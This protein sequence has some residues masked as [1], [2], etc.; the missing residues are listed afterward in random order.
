MMR[1]CICFLLPLIV[2][3]G[4]AQQPVGSLLYEVRI[5]GQR[6]PGY[7]FGTVHLADSSLVSWSRP[8]HRALRRCRIVAGE[9]NLLNPAEQLQS[10][11][12][13]LMKDTL[14]SDL[15]S[16]ADSAVVWGAIRRSADP[17]LAVLAN[18]MKPMVLAVALLEQVKPSEIHLIPDVRIQQVGAEK[19]KRIVAL[20]TAEEHYGAMDFLSYRE[21]TRLLVD[22]AGSADSLRAAFEPMRK[23]YLRGDVELLAELDELEQLPG[24]AVYHLITVRNRRMTERFIELSG[25]G[26]VFAAVGAAHLHGDEGMLAL[27]QNRN[28]VITPVEFSFLSD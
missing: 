23:A 24:D 3:V 8:F 21:Q 17:S 1:W 4:H 11:R 16:P 19:E 25:Q 7:L 13:I 28:C 9:V 5:P 27:L 20:E 14:L 15:L 6:R 26:P 22:L 18:R 10:L 2:L 12:Y